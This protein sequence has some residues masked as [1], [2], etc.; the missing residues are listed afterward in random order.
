MAVAL[1]MPSSVRHNV[2]KRLARNNLVVG[3]L[4]RSCFTDICSLAVNADG[5]ASG[6]LGVLASLTDPPHK[7]SVELR[8]LP[9]SPHFRF[10]ELSQPI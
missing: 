1:W 10:P 7:T 4:A 9:P 8:W 2:G 6:V 3:T 5:T